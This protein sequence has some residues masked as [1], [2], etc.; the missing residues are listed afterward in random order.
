MLLGR[1]ALCAL[2]GVAGCTGRRA[3]GEGGEPDGGLPPP[4]TAAP[5]ASAQTG[6]P[7]GSAQTSPP[8][9]ADAGDAVVPSTMPTGPCEHAPGV[10][11]VSS[12]QTP[13]AG[14][15][16][17][18]VVVAEQPAP[19]ALL[20]VGSEHGD[21][22]AH[23]AAGR[24]GPPYWWYAEVVPARAGPLRA[25]LAAE[26]RALACT[27]VSVLDE[28]PPPARQGYPVWP[29]ERS[30]DRAMELVYSTWIE[31][32]FDD[33]LDAQPSWPALH[34]VLRDA[35]R[36]F[37]HGH[38]GL[39]EDDVARGAPI[40]DPDCADLPFFL[41]GYFAFKMG[42]PFGYTAC[43]RGGGGQPPR[44]SSRFGTNLTAVRRG[45]RSSTATVFGDFMRSNVA[46]TVHSGSGRVAADDDHADFYP[47]PLTPESLR[48]G[49]I[50]ADP[51]GHVLVL[52]RRIAQSPTAAG[53]LLAVDGQPDGTVGRKRFWRGNFLFATDPALGSPGFK[54]FRPVVLDGRR[55]RQL[56]NAEIADNPQWADVSMEQT[57]LEVE[58]FYDKMD[59]LLSPRPLDPERA[60]LEIVQALEEQIGVRVTSVANGDAYFKK[61]GDRIDMPDGPS[62]FETTGGWEDFS[63]PSRDLRL[64][65]AID[66]ARGLPERVARRLERYAT[67]GG[68]APA[69]VREALTATLTRELANRKVTYPRSDGSSWTLTLA[70]VVARATALEM[71]YNPNDCPELRWGAPAGS[72]EAKTCHRRAPGDQ[73]AKMARY[74]TWF[75]DRRR[76]PRG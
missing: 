60:L 18:I 43:S 49:T 9:A 30:W 57:S 19:S 34:E 46:D 69:E 35:R 64:L 25:A 58:G 70:D 65:I 26:G 61:G 67:T 45:R 5:D 31:K 17:R 72:E 36:N 15:P 55:L 71:A 44:C 8:G 50:Y 40:L 20:V 47:V 23:S 74:R 10:T 3:G 2:V 63:T 68:K 52:V 16:L 73:R 1:L 11:I 62:I 14:V 22:V 42:L 56:S 32:L 37:L 75:H 13:V 6:P 39:G 76:P 21:V 48:P 41:R 33:P 28:A 51:Y 38:L 54:R 53:V 4:A 27:S 66:V 24:G 7:D 59:D 12:P 29:V